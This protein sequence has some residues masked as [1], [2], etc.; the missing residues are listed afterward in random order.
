[1]QE[2]FRPNP[3]DQQDFIKNQTKKV[4]QNTGVSSEKQRELWKKVQKELAKT[5]AHEKRLDDLDNG[6]EEAY[7]SGDNAYEDL[8]P[9]PD[10]LREALAYVN[11]STLVDNLMGGIEN[12]FGN[13]STTLDAQ[14][15]SFSA[16][17]E[18]DA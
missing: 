11:A 10:K 6:F 3:L 14:I 15:E 18:F 5:E 4:E 16:L 12:Q 7:E 8:K 2:S 17:D 1:M 9:N 13:S